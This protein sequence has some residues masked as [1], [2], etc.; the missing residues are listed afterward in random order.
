MKGLFF[1]VGGVDFEVMSEV[2]TRV[3]DGESDFKVVVMNLKTNKITMMD[4]EM[5]AISSAT[6][7]KT[8]DG[9]CSQCKNLC[10]KC[11]FD[12]AS[13]KCEGDDIKFGNGRGNDNVIECLIFKEKS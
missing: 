9:G 10:K 5:S 12:F 13:C 11:V 4:I 7:S 3:R 8:R 2:A 1:K 6:F